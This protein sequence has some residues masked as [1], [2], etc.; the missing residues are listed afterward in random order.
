MTIVKPVIVSESIPSR[1]I[2]ALFI[3]LIGVSFASALIK[4]SMVTFESHPVEIAF[5]RLF[6]ATLLMTGAMILGGQGRT[7]VEE[8]KTL[9]K[10]DIGILIISGLFLAIHFSS[11]IASLLPSFTTVAASVLIVDSSPIMVALLAY[12]A[13]REKISRWQ[14]LG[15][16]IAISGGLII[17]GGDLLSSL[18]SF[19]GDILAFIGAMS[20]AVYFVAGRRLRG[21]IGLFAYVIP[22][23][24]ICTIFLFGLALIVGAPL[25]FTPAFAM[26]LFI[27]M[28]I[29]PSC[30]GH[31][32]YNYSIRWI[33]APVISTVTL[34]EALLAPIIAL[35][36]VPGEVFPPIWVFLG[37]GVLLSGILLTIWME[38]RSEDNESNETEVDLEATEYQYR[39]SNSNSST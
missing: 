39:D 1:A 19:A 21:H 12:V 25:L 23:Y 2:I 22:V 9:E 6:W 7:T 4:L 26:I 38:R 15:I 36:L 31:T 32:L 8:W 3:A 28:A 20:V 17:G 16:A 13:L 11:W 35:L 30:L 5:W 18:Q 34:G 14:V 33:K 37:G 24:G 29:G 27:L 10:K